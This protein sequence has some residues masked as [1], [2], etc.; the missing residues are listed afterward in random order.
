MSN[1]IRISE[2]SPGSERL[3]MSNRGT[4]CFLDLLISAAAGL[5]KT[6]CQRELTAFLEDRR[7]MNDIAPGTAGFDIVDMPWEEGSILE[8]K[9]FLLRAAEAAGTEAVIAK[10][11]YEI[12]QE[13]VLPWL[14][15]FGAMV[16]QAELGRG[17]QPSV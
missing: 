8:D 14:K 10:L 16:E 11:P 3:V 4:D 1:I 5:E 12:N 9:R 6:G 13:L 7:K 15:Q 2:S 17:R